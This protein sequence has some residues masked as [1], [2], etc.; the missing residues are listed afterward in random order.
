MAKSETVEDKRLEAGRAEVGGEK[1]A[2]FLRRG[3]HLEGMARRH[4]WRGWHW[5]VWFCHSR[6]GSTVG[7][8]RA[9]KDRGRGKTRAFWIRDV[10]GFSSK[11]RR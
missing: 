9:R 5:A 1:E 3:V 11:R 10:W 2:S 4:A 7:Q 6:E 8:G